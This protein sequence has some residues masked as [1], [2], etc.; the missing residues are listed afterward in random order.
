MAT[1]LDGFVFN[2]TEYAIC[3]TTAREQIAAQ[4]ASRTEVNAD[5]AAEVI[6]AR[7][8]D[9]GELYPTLGE[10][11]RKQIYALKMA[12]GVAT[13]SRF[14]GKTF[15]ILGDGVT[16]LQGFLPTDCVSWYDGVNGEVAELGHT[17]WGKLISGVGMEL[18]VNN[19]WDGTKLIFDGTNANSFMAGD[20]RIH[21][22]GNNAPD[23]LFVMCGKDDMAAETTLGEFT[24]ELVNLEDIQDTDLDNFASAYKVMLQRLMTKF[25][26]T[27]IVV[28]WYHNMSSCP[29]IEAPDYTTQYQFAEVAEKTAKFYGCQWIDLRKAGINMVNNSELDVENYPTKDGHELYYQYIIQE[30]R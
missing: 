6:D 22:L 18:L 13:Q 7:V 28:L 19:S 20:A 29:T 25:S 16:T 9:G 1:K 2:G 17:F 10:A 23:Y 26:T 15:S 4:I 5:Y 3:D 24:P 8:G 21:K 27:K 11:I 14:K 30:L 12:L